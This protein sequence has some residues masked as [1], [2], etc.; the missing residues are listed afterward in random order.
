MMENFNVKEK[1]KKKS[2]HFIEYQ[3]ANS[4]YGT[5][6]LKDIIEF[7]IE[8]QEITGE[9]LKSDSKTFLKGKEKLKDAKIRREEMAKW[10]QKTK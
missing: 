3:R 2:D 10:M 6:Q 8:W 5:W 7:C 9:I 1:R 4:R